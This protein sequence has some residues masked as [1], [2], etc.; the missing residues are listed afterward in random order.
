MDPPLAVPPAVPLPVAM[1]AAPIAP[2]L[3]ELDFPVGEFDDDDTDEMLDQLFANQLNADDQNI[4]V[5]DLPVFVPDVQEGGFPAA[6]NPAPNPPPP[7]VGFTPP[8]FH[9]VPV[10]K[11]SFLIRVLFSVQ[12][13]W[14]L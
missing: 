3:D 7:E 14:T 1:P 8:T 10:S 9:A 2:W 13:I 4:Q 12:P 11:P 6:P 5:G